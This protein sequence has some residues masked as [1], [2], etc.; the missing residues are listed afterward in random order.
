M[1][2]KTRTHSLDLFTK[3]LS[4]VSLSN[5]GDSKDETH[6]K[7][8][9]SDDILYQWRL[10]RRL[11]EARRDVAAAKRERQRKKIIEQS[12]KENH[13][14]SQ[15]CSSLNTQQP[16]CHKNYTIP[17]PVSSGRCGPSLQLEREGESD[18][19]QLEE[20]LDD[21]FDSSLSSF[22]SSVAS[23]EGPPTKRKDIDNLLSEV[24]SLRIVLL[25]LL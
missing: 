9:E 12:N 17:I 2:I 16:S 13:S 24:V 5:D 20:S 22:S 23:S 3:S 7:M 1:T 14:I 8:K 15:H 11:E 21:S 6:L 10:N 18:G 4:D 25:S 19:G